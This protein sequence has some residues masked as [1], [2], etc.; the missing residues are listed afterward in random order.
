MRVIIYCAHADDLILGAGG[1]LA[2][3]S[4]ENEVIAVFATDGLLH[5]P[6]YTDTRSWAEE[7]CEVLGITDIKWL[8]VPNMRFDTFALIDINQRFEN[9][10]LL[11]DLLITNSISELNRDHRLIYESARVFTRPNSKKKINV[12]SFESTV[13]KIGE[14]NPQ[15]FIDISSTIDKKIK[16]MS[17][18]RTEMKPYPHPRSGEAIRIRAQYW[19]LYSGMNLAEPFEVIRWYG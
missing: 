3:L 6:K 19:G 4:E 16:A 5:A 14:F 11:P 15:Y 18:F 12:L 7:G 8:N 9:L 2:Q 1:Y 13:W 17:K 10:N